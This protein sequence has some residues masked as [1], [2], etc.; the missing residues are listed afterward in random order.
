MSRFYDTTDPDGPKELYSYTT[1]RGDTLTP[2]MR[3]VYE[4]PSL[5]RAGI[6]GTL[7]IT[8]LIDLGDMSDADPELDP[9]SH[10]VTAILNEGVWEVA[11]DNLRP[12]PE[13]DEKEAERIQS[14]WRLP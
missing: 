5:D 1:D 8:E 11:A 12:E 4:N 6:E 9:G 14:A 7:K 13:P 2:G 3:V 10:H